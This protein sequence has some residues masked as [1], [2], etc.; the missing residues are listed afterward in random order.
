MADRAMGNLKRCGSFGR[1]VRRMAREARTKT[2]PALCD[3][4]IGHMNAGS[5]VNDMT[6]P[7]AG[8]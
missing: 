1:L 2:A 3:S 7:T 5:R 6:P 4:G 8:T